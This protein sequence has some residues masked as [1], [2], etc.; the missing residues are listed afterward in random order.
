MNKTDIF[1]LYTDYLITS[2]SY[3][4]AT[5]LSNI[6]DD[7]VSHDQVTRFLSQQ[8]LTS[9]ERWKVIKKTAREIESDDGILI[10]DDT[11]QEKRHSK[12]NDLICWHYDHT[13]N[14]SVKGINLLNGLYYSNEVSLPVAFEL[15]K[16]PIRFCDIKTK[17]EKR[18]S[19]ITKNQ[20]L[21][22]ML[23]V[24]CKNHLKW[25]YALADS[26][27][28]SAENMQYIHYTLKKYFIFA[29]KSNRLIALTKEDKAKGRFTRID[30]ITWSEDPV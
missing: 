24:C 8:D 27:F 19:T 20:Q 28:S 26:W 29:L 6:L 30:R 1:D 3:T 23:K 5:G 15:V 21:R 9:K 13:V 11:V 18:K 12:E 7:A 10:F 22:D 14:R 4:T 2:F 17:T 16:K 25:R